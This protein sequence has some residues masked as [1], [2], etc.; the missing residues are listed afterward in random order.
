MGALRSV[1]HLAARQFGV[2]SR[3]QVLALG[4]TPR[5]VGRRKAIGEWE[6]MLPGVFRIVAVPISF[7]QRAMATALWAGPDAL[8]S[9]RSAATLAL[10]E[11]VRRPTTIDITIGSHRRLAH[12]GVT[13][14]TTGD[15]IPADRS[16]AGSIPVT[17]PLRTVLDLAAFLDPVALEV[18][19]ECCLRR[20]LFTVGQLRW[21]ADARL[22]R[23]VAGSAELHR[24]LGRRDLGRSDSA[25]EVRLGAAL[26][27][28]GL[29]APERQ[30]RVRTV[31][32]DFRVD[33]GYGGSP[34][35]AF[36]YDSD[37]WHSTVHR[38]HADAARRNA[39]RA[40]GVVVIE[41]TSALMRDERALVQLAQ[42]VLLRAA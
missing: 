40:A 35:V 30:L 2:I 34:V 17:S 19:I 32:G 13:V 6:A 5:M 36:E 3:A 42:H 41:V 22:G 7:R 33:V 8:I 25:W 39:L 16:A 27:A 4:M 11:G 12:D 9:H 18:A 37:R 26:V 38:R 10:M 20:G 28:G 24:L 14:H 29:P 31:H 23:G 1:E 15:R 21:R